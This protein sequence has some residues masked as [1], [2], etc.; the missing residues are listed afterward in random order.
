[1]FRRP[2]GDAPAPRGRVHPE[3]RLPARSGAASHAESRAGSSTVSRRTRT[4]CVR[5]VASAAARGVTDG[6]DCAV[7]SSDGRRQEWRAGSSP[8]QF[9]HGGEPLELLNTAVS[10]RLRGETARSREPLAHLGKILADAGKRQ[11]GDDEAAADWGTPAIRHQSCQRLTQR[12][13]GTPETSGLLD[14]L[15]ARSP[16]AAPH[17]TISSRG[18]GMPGRFARWVTAIASLRPQ[19]VV[20]YTL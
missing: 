7:E 14:L 2:G 10:P 19:V 1:M 17:S 3:R 11:V 20:V 16:A 6:V 9:V 13:A 4:R 12:G 8:R 5:R 15:R 18:S